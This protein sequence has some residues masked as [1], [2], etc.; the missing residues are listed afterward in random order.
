MIQPERILI[1]V[2]FSTDAKALIKIL[3]MLRIESRCHIT[4]A[5][6]V[7]D[8]QSEIAVYLKDAEP[9]RLQKAMEE[10]AAALFEKLV[11][12]KLKL[13]NQ[14]ETVVGKGNSAEFILNL[15][16][17]MKADLIIMGN[18]DAGKAAGSRFGSTADKVVRNAPCP[19]LIVPLREI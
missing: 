4:L 15:A 2:D 5:H 1:G 12:K 16:Q 18:S 17:R 10:R 9:A 14:W 19:V 8:L 7:P 11:D 13:D 3:N 6:A